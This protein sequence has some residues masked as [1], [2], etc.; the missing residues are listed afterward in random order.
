MPDVGLEISTRAWGGVIECW[1]HY[2][3]GPKLLPCVYSCHSL[4]HFLYLYRF[5]RIEIYGDRWARALLSQTKKSRNQAV[6]LIA[7]RYNVWRS[8]GKRVWIL[9]YLQQTFRR[10]VECSVAVSLQS[11]RQSLGKELAWFITTHRL[12]AR[13]PWDILGWKGWCL[14]QDLTRTYACAKLRCCRGRRRVLGTHGRGGPCEIAVT[15]TTE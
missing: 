11:E 1:L 10:E 8:E 13:G 3:I 2:I 4:Y 15:A 14:A 7:L 6:R 12:R 9:F 5:F